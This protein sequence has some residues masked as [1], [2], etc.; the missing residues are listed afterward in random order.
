M[1]LNPV[2]LDEL[3]KRY[4]FS[5]LDVGDAGVR[6]YSLR[7]GYFLNADLVAIQVGANLEEAKRQL[8]QT[9]FACSTKSFRSMADAENQLFEGFF[10]ADSSRERLHQEYERF[11]GKI[12]R[13]L[14]NK[15]EY[16][17]GPFETVGFAPQPNE[18]VVQC[19][20]GLL[21]TPGPT[22]VILEAAAGFGKSCTAFEILRQML[23]ERRDQV[24]LLTELSLNRQAKIFRYVLLDEIDRNFP[25]LRSQLVRE[26][27][28]AG[29][30]PLIVD[31]FDELLSRTGATT[32]H[33]EE[34]EPMLETISALLRDQAK[35]LIATRRTAIFSRDEFEQWLTNQPVP[36]SVFRVRLNNPS[37]DDWL[38][39]ER[40]KQ[41]ATHSQSIRELSNPVLLSFLRAV[42]DTRFQ[43]LC[44]SPGEITTSYFASLLERERE[45]QDLLL[46]VPD[47]L[48]VFERLASEMARMRFMSEDRDYLE[49][50][51]TV[52]NPEL[53]EQARLEYRKDAR[54][55]IDELATKLAGH[56]LLD[57]RGPEDSKIGFV[58]DFILG[59]L[60]GRAI[61]DGIIDVS[62]ISDFET[63]VDLTVTAFA[64]EAPFRRQL[65]WERLAEIIPLFDANRQVEIDFSLTNQSQR[66]FSNESFSGLR[67]RN[68]QVGAQYKL[69]NCLFVNCTFTTL[70]ANMSETLLFP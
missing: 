58:N 36:F 41:L 18:N 3:Y 65:L 4:G 56:A 63:F 15:Y 14:G 33:F 16:I 59:S 49:L 60:L 29:R 26:Q 53:L 22:L 44:E 62:A 20:L 54:P 17:A 28:Q 5:V 21:R 42:P 11:S 61:V 13:T 10:A 57:R 40:V 32:D 48:V 38:G 23:A 67:V 50:C 27:I 1:T 47:Q 9:G 55:T 43:E 35:V 64:V 34:A 25:S 8:E 46:S 12:T 30:M 7:T 51:I 66:D 19:L 45:R 24:P 69:D 52:G 31:G 70:S 6:A 37:L 2:E 68:V 39:S